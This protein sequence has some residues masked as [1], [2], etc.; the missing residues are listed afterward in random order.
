M[1]RSTAEV[2]DE[3]HLALRLAAAWGRVEQRLNGALGD[4]RGT[5]FAEYRLLRAIDLAPD[6][7]ISR[8]ELARRVGLSASGVTRA[9]R[10]L[11]KLGYVETI[12][13][14]RDARLALASLTDPGRELLADASQLV[15]ETMVEVTMTVPEL[16]AD[17]DLLDRLL[18]ALATR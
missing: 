1:S 3:Q 7:R 5:T 18:D 8:I 14:E 11:E 13:A 16:R 17:R 12:K 6:G 15:H 4:H 9:L 10:P 2:T